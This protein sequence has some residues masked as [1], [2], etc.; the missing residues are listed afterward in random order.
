MKSFAATTNTDGTTQSTTLQRPS[1][2]RAK[3][4]RLTGSSRRAGYPEYGNGTSC[5]RRATTAS[6]T[7]KRY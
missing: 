6:G 1:V 4:K 5:E 3:K 2:G 7:S